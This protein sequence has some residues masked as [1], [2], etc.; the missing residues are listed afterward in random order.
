M[1]LLP[2]LG[3]RGGVRGNG[4]ST[5]GRRIV[6]PGN[7]RGSGGASPSP[8]GEGRGEGEWVA[9]HTSA[10]EM[11]DP[12]KVQRAQPYSKTCR[13]SRRLT[14]CAKRRGV[15]LPPAAFVRLPPLD[16]CNR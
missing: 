10:F 4:S 9:Q 16:C 1:V 2:L 3:E 5:I 13:I 7:V 14:K 15:R 6:C 8:R 12:C 11:K